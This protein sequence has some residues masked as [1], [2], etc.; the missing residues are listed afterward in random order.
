MLSIRMIQKPHESEK[1]DLQ[2]HIVEWTPLSSKREARSRTYSSR[3]RLLA[4]LCLIPHWLQ[5]TGTECSR[6]SLRGLRSR[7]M[8]NQSWFTS[9]CCLVL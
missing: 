9:I 1:Y 7:S 5:K 6:E 4:T 2:I 3:P 8:R